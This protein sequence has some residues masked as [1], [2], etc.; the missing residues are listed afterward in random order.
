M[1]E[2]LLTQ[3]VNEAEEAIESG[4]YGG[5]IEACQRILGQFPE[6]ASA[7]RIMAEA[8]AEKGDYEAAREAFQRT[9]ERDPQSIAAHLGLGMLA[10]EAGDR[11]SALA[12][13]QVAWEIDPRRRDLREHVSRISQQLYGADGRLYLTRAALASLHFHAGRWDRAVTEA[14]QVLQDYPSRVDVQVRLAESLW[15]RGDDEQARQVCESVLRALPQAVVPLLMLADIH[16]RQGDQQSAQDYLSQARDIDPDGVRAADLIVVGFDDQADFLSVD[17]IPTIDDQI[18]HE[19]PARYA[20]APDFTASDSEDIAAPSGESGEDVVVPTQPELG[21][22]QTPT[23]LSDLDTSDVQPFRWEDIG[24]VDLEGDDFDVPADDLAAEGSEPTGDLSEFSLPTD[25]E[26]QQAR[27]GEERE[28]GYTEML[29]SLKSQGVEPF[30]PGGGQEKDQ[31]EAA[32]GSPADADDFSLDDFTMPSDEELEQARP[33][34]EHPAGYTGTLSSL[35]EQGVQPFDPTGGAAGEQQ[36][37]AGQPGELEMPDEAEEA[38]VEA[39]ASEEGESL[40]DWLGE[41]SLPSDEEIQEARPED[42]RPAGYTGMLSSLEDE[43]MEPFDPGMPA[44][45]TTAPDTE[46]PGTA[47]EPIDSSEGEG[48]LELDELGQ[49]SPFQIDWSDIDQEIEEAIPGEMPRGYTE[50]LRSLDDGGLEPFDFEG[51]AEASEMA[52]GLA[53]SESSAFEPESSDDVWLTAQAED[54]EDV[55]ELPV[56]EAADVESIGALFPEESDQQYAETERLETPVGPE[57]EN[58]AGQYEVVEED[59]E[60]SDGLPGTDELS[61]G[62]EPGGTAAASEVDESLVE[63][64]DELDAPAD[65]FPTPAPVARETSVST[66][67]PSSHV[68]AERL[69]LDEELIDR[70]RSAKQSLID[71]GRIDGRK[72]LPGAGVA[73]GADVDA[74]RAEIERDPEN[75]ESRIE[76]ARELLETSPDLA[77]E[78][79]RWLYRNAPERGA[80]VVRDLGQL[81][82][83][84]REREVGVHRLLGALY[85]RH[86]DWGAAA[87]HYEEALSN[88]YVRRQ[89]KRDGSGG[90]GR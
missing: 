45:S 27:P 4:N 1:A 81:I 57:T 39:V 43:G 60:F 48:T 19:E 73:V 49:E 28:R 59:W 74:L 13:V 88:R 72:R 34:G 66:A 50:E 18:V 41:F 38:D 84:M 52:E 55:P 54:S 89:T 80:D 7:H 16:R 2:V 63:Q 36:S 78:Q 20:P 90:Y 9:L 69:G 77:L 17:D 22:E 62:G 47:A 76:F 25:E 56:E 10:E 11:E 79:Y 26:L 23:D 58:A 75:V 32:T 29:D 85:R 3:A 33:S 12:Y 15:R 24:D 31:G 70:A 61:M 64:E 71:E 51:D 42:E 21:A 35:E 68:S 86:G 65:A 87:T 14:A 44:E 5:A 8:Y 53:E 83:V 37:M 46:R 67:G 30:D 6:F 40:D 82:A